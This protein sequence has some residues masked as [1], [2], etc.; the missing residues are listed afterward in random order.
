MNPLQEAIMINN[1]GVRLLSYGNI[2][3]ALHSFQNAVTMMKEVAVA[4][5]EKPRAIPPNDSSCSR[6]EPAPERPGN[7]VGLQNEACY[8]YDRPLLIPTDFNIATLEEQDSF[9]LMSSTFV[10]FNFA[11][12]CHQFGKISGN[13]VHLLR[14]GQLYEL[15]LKILSSAERDH[16]MHSVLQCLAL[17]NLAQL[18][19]DQCD[20]QKSQS[21]MESMFD[22]VMT[23]DCLDTHLSE[24]EVEELMLN[25]VHMQPPTVAPAA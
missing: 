10:I 12:A 8:I 23:T 20:Y 19:Y 24:K 17:N 5:A 21:Y 22:L 25:L 6:F 15:T 4:Q 13:E 7:L 14:A 16:A 11:L 9:M 2:S 3:C 1:E 18:H